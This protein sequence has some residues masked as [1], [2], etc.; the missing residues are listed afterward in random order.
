MLDGSSP[1]S[2][3]HSRFANPECTSGINSCATIDPATNY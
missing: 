2:R 3:L 1:P